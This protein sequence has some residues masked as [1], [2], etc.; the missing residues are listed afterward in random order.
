M[1]AIESSLKLMDNYDL[2]RFQLNLHHLQI[3]P[4]WVVNESLHAFGIIVGITVE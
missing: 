2:F 4:Q 3:H 1:F